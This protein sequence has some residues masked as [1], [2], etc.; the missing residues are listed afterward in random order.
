MNKPLKIAIFG[1]GSTGCFLA[2]ELALAGL[3]VTLICR[4][5]IKD[6]IL[7]SGGIRLTDFQGLD[8][9]V[10]P[11]QLFTQVGGRSVS[12]S[13]NGGEINSSYERY[14]LV[15][16][17]VKCHQ[18]NSI[19]AELL[20]ISCDDTQ[21]I[22]M[23]NGLGSLNAIKP[24]LAQR[25]LLQG[26]TPF[27]VLQLANGRFHKGTEGR[28]IFQ[29]TLMLEGVKVALQA[30]G[31]DCELTPNIDAV[32]HGK[33]L[34][35][36]NNALNAIADF[37]IKQQLANRDNRQLLALAMKEWLTICKIAGIELQ[38]FTKVKPQYLPML[39]NLPDFIFTRLAKNMLDIDDK[40]RSSMWEDI[41]SN[42]PTEIDYLNGA[43]VRLGKEYGVKTPVN[44]AI[45]N[46]IKQLEQG[47]KL[48][49]TQ[50]IQQISQR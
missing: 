19:V 8:K 12:G 11:R 45:V 10:M 29:K 50:L 36:L 47:H 30:H 14:D 16:V 28:F 5:R 48:S 37:P 3:N 6:A 1:A 31:L 41:Q 43:V 23:Q 39:L 21:I 40:A 42:R 17:T 24:F 7:E 32:I 38:Q 26:I 25:K 22:F 44:S 18:L 49:L 20:A 2:G 13:D 4:E 46:A 27:N 34:L 33:L 35:N 9:T 15:L